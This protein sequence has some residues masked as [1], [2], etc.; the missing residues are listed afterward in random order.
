MRQQR[1]NGHFFKI[2]IMSLMVV[3]VLQNHVSIEEKEMNIGTLQLNQAVLTAGNLAII[4]LVAIFAYLLFKKGLKALLLR[5][6]ISRSIYSIGK[7]T[8]KWIV[9]F[10]IL[11]LALQQIG[12]RVG[13][14]LTALLTMAGMVAIGFI[15]VWSILSNILCSFLLI[16]FGAF[17]ID[18]EIEIVEPTGGDGLK[19]KVV[20]FNV[21]FTTIVEQSDSNKDGFLTQIPN[22]IF[23]Q[24]T[25]R[26]KSGNKKESL[27]QHLLSKPVPF[28]LKKKTTSS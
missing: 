12:I 23:F 9:L 7:N 14:I 27:G 26:R 13:N 3:S 11:I 19:G 16:V 15:A 8:I 1:I 6:Y 21:M 22:N 5:D 18:D 10:A 17:N 4:V 24:K 20:N 25:L 28:E 2:E